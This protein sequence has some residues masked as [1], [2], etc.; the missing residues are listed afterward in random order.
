MTFPT[1]SLLATLLL[2]PAI[3]SAQE[4]SA[5]DDETNLI[6]NG[7]FETVEGKLKRVG[8]IEMA[9]G[10][11]SPTASKADLFNGLS[12]GT[13]VSGGINQFGDQSALNGTGFAGLRWWSFQNKQPRSYLQAKFKTMLKKGQ[14][15]CVKY[16]VS[17]GDLSR[18]ATNEIGAYIGK[19]PVN[20]DDE[21]S[22]T[23]AAQ[24]P[25][26]RANIQKDMYTWQGVCG[27]YE[28]TGTEQ[29]LF[30]GNFTPTE[31]TL[32]EQVTRPKG[33]TRP[34]LM[35]AYYYIDEVSVTPVKSD[36]DCSCKQIDEAESE[37]IF[38]RKGALN[39]SAKPAEVV[40]AQV[41]YFKRFQHN[42]DRSME[43][44]IEEMA[45]TMKAEPTIKVRL[46]GHID[47]T[48]KD[49]ERMRPDMATLGQ[50]RADTI[51]AALV[52]AGVEATRITTSGK[53]SEVP[54][55]RTGSEVGMS[56]NRRVEVELVK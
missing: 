29:Y 16:Y 41:F 14:K 48:E 7:G 27:V 18:Y 5:Q 49:R 11:K 56:K 38:S 17:L 32:N 39:P 55:D 34:Q 28:G 31:K 45:T 40:D 22:L 1:L 6:Q 51:K 37:L 10:W 19:T 8:S 15:Y 33:E 53:G 47:D 42:I 46:I 21:A 25:H 12:P 36:A 43:P 4:K 50:K 23:Y 2:T 24:V 9:T 3:L 30:I 26:L 20:K 35:H 54:A 13:P 52:E 44:W